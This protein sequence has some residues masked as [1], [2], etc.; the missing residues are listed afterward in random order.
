M[1]KQLL[2]G[3]S[4]LA[5]MTFAP[6]TGAGGGAAGGGE[7]GAAGAGA[8]GAA[9]VKDQ[10]G[11]GGAAAG[12][13]AASGGAAA[14]GA[15]AGQ[16]GS[17]SGDRTAGGATQ[18]DWRDAMAGDDKGFRERL[19][20]FTEPAAF[21]RSYRELEGKL[22][23]GQ[24]RPATAFPK[25]GT[26]EEQAT[27][28][29]DMGVPENAEAYKIE[30]PD[31]MVAGEAD[32]P[33]LGR[34]ATLAHSQ[35]WTNGQYN[36]AVEAYYREID[37]A[38]AARAEADA[39]FRRDS[40]AQLE[41]DWGGDYKRNTAAVANLMAT[42]PKDVADALLGGRTADGRRIGDHP[43]VLKVLAQQAFDLNPAATILPAG[44]QDV[45]GI[46][47]R[48]GELKTMMA[49]QNSDYWKGAKA[50]GLQKEYRDLIDAEQRIKKRPAA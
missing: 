49:D 30:L 29:K 42:W 13:A 39:D 11:A 28:R 14:D 35:N 17:G 38:H 19:N 2:G 15:A 45:A 33:A 5:L 18:P 16:G 21:A 27:W 34:L 6:E 32:K 23:S 48:K 20:R 31:G 46:E 3:T 47:Q 37:A 36:Q 12:A 9:A 43:G 25:D 4:P 26:A 8:A 44:R 1:L 10:A 22:S 24:Y 40:T 50:A 7:G 41:K